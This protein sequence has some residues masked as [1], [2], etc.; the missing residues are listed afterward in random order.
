MR[1]IPNSCPC[2]KALSNNETINTMGFKMFACSNCGLWYCNPADLPEMNYNEVYGSKEYQELHFGSLDATKDWAKFA[3]YPTYAPFFSNIPQKQNDKLLDVGCGVGRFC[4]AAYTNGWN[5]KGID[6]SQ[7]AID[8]GRE[9]ALFPMQCVNIQEFYSQTNETF[10]VVTSFEVLEHLT[11]PMEFLET[12]NKS[13][14]PGGYFFCTVP[15]LDSLSVQTSNRPDWIPPVHVLF[16]T[17]RALHELLKNAG[18]RDIQTGV[19]WMDSPPENIG[20]NKIKYL[21][22]KVLGKTMPI[23][24]PLGL[25]AMGKK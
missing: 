17:R 2:C 24:D 1:E 6:I 5:V 10:D 20:W 25:W 7:K 9:T 21:L 14:N 19:I 15:N 12:I 8:K 22:K 23:P 18:F 13:V 11:A 16:F 4:R 3:K